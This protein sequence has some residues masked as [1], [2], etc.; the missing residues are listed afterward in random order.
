MCQ[1]KK[2][3]V[4]KRLLWLILLLCYFGSQ[5][6]GQRDDLAWE[7]ISIDQGLA[8]SY[9]L[10]I[11]Q[12]RQGLLWFGTQDGLSRY[13]GYQ[14]TTFKNNPQ[15]PNSL[16]DNFITS[17]AKDSHGTIWIG[18]AYG[19]LSSYNPSTQQFRNFPSN[20]LDSHIISLTID[21]QDTI[22]VSTPKTL[23]LI[24]G[25]QA[26]PFQT[27]V[28]NYYDLTNVS[29]HFT[30]IDN[31]GIVWLATNNGL[32]KYNPANQQRS[33]YLN[34]PQNPASLSDNNLR[35][36]TGDNQG[37]LWLGTNK[38]LDR[39]DY[40]TE[41]ITHY[42]HNPNEKNSLVDNDIKHI[43][44]DNPPN[45]WISTYNGLSCFNTQSNIFT[46]YQS[47]PNNP[48]SLGNNHI[49]RVY[50][51]RSQVLWIAL[52]DNGLAKYD[53][54][55]HRFNTY[56]HNPY[57]SNSLIGD[58]IQAIY[59]DHQGIWWISTREALNLY[60]PQTKKSSIIKD[61]SSPNVIYED[62]DGL[63]WLGTKSGMYLFDQQQH[64]FLSLAA[65]YPALATPLLD[66]PII[67]IYQDPQNN[68]WFGL[69]GKGLLYYNVKTQLVK[70]YQNNNDSESLSN[71]RVIQTY[72]DR[73]GLMWFATLGGG[74]T[75]YQPNSNKFNIYNPRLNN[76]P[77]NQVFSIIEDKA[78]MLWFGTADGL[79]QYN[80][81]RAAFTAFTEHDGLPNNLIYGILEDAKGNLWLSTNKG[82][83]K[84]QPQNGTFRNYDFND[85]LQSNEFNY[86]AYYKSAQGELFFGGIK[87]VSEF[88][89]ED[90]Q[91]NNFIAPLAITAFKVFNNRNELI[92][93]QK[94]TPNSAISLS[95]NENFIELEFATLNYQQPAKNQY[96][97]WLA[98]VDETW[99]YRGNRHDMRY[100]NLPPGDYTFQVKASNNDGLWGEPL[101]ISFTI[102]PPFWRTWWAY[103]SYLLFILSAIYT[104]HHYRVYKL[105]K[106]NYLLE[107]KVSE[108]TAEVDQKNNQLQ[109]KNIELAQQNRELMESNQRADRIFSA[110]AEALPGTILDD[111]YHLDTKIGSGGFGVVYQA[112][113]L[114]IKRP[115]AIKIF[116]PIP[117]NDSPESL[118]RF[119]LEAISACRVNHPNAIAI[120]D[121]G[122]S[123]DGIAYLVM[124]LL[125]GHT[126]TQELR[127]KGK[128]TAT[129]ALEII[130]PVCSALARA[131]SVGI[132]HRDI[133]P[134][135][136]FLH[137]APE[138]EIVKVVDFGIAKVMATNNSIDIKDLTE[139][140]GIIG[141]PTYMAPERFSSQ[142]YD[143]RADVYSLGIML[144]EMLTGVTPF[145]Q[146]GESI[147]TI[148][149]SHISQI[150]S[151]LHELDPSISPEL[152]Q[153]IL[154][155]LVKQPA[156][157]PTAQEWATELAQVAGIK[158]ETISKER[159][160]TKE[161][162]SS[163]SRTIMH[164]PKSQD[165]P[166]HT[167]GSE[168][169]SSTQQHTLLHPSK[170][171][172]QI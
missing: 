146:A 115:V 62:H 65:K 42:Q 26:T 34:D 144:Y 132:I 32:Y 54:S 110:L 88:R 18:T 15:D 96:A 92:P 20:R 25:E 35:Y 94:S 71:S 56:R 167:T 138:G 148:M 19:G 123:T 30:Y 108:R 89:P 9:V 112:T 158:L 8:Q 85:G 11:L 67:S 37:H 76:F 99:V 162:F 63:M 47:D 60:N 125:D 142:D 66:V 53:P 33:H 101:A 69:L 29:I 36:L 24:K 93:S 57:D 118:E 51:D 14:F 117:G 55:R 49:S 27:Q 70:H 21:A 38:G 152:S 46:N 168:E 107:V 120:L 58:S 128:L 126:L 161:H 133:K 149:L 156:E 2:L 75:T 150:P 139:Q 171:R 134:D 131:H 48:T 22:W 90:I 166:A 3:R 72:Q 151:P 87:G 40:Q 13:D 1:A 5:A 127:N 116:K 73:R 31:Q 137:Q 122:I 97:C 102:K 106:Q 100:S 170:D 160:V 153:V 109:L 155:A 143:G 6:F 113:N 23:Y 91:D 77:S 59:K 83:S 43:Y 78:G 41:K 52:L 104:G 119:R 169:K 74:L 145:A 165:I 121:S 81:S 105:E 103:I 154:K 111:K 130:L 12:D 163:D 136:I 140:G 10:A 7:S 172:K 45:I 141:T 84:F 95:Y 124:E 80:P 79:V 17:L 86:S 98:G 129:R 64:K 4:M 164:M 135:N 16:P 114:V 50:R 157:R 159:P 44:V 82:L 147:L 61:I 39:F 28:N 68:Y